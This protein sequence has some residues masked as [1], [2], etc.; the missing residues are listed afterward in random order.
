[1]EYY[2]KKG[3]LHYAWYILIVCFLLNMI[4]QAFVMSVSNL[5]VVPIWKEFQVS[6]SLVTM[7]SICITISSVLSAP[8][9]GRLYRNRSARIL[10]PS[11]L[12]GTAI[13]CFIRS[14]CPNI[15]CVLLCAFF[16]GIFFTGSTL[17][18]ISILLTAWFA[19]KRGF[20]ISV[21]AIGSSTG[22]VIMS[23]FV[24]YLIVKF[25]W[26]HA[27]QIMAFLIFSLCVP[28]T[29]LVIRNKPRDIG[30]FAWGGK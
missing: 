16:K 14:L 9:W 27:D 20:A 5:Y 4:V 12:T 28:M 23:P 19:K 8:I 22:G 17:L 25:G 11:A 30:I 29:Y 10:L 2:E 6:R 24:N 21:A 18:P 7:Q 15:Y 3:N 13:C 26:R 1:M